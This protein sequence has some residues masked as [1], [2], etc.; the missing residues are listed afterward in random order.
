MHENGR[1]GHPSS[2]DLAWGAVI[3]AV[4]RDRRFPGARLGQ[5]TRG[6]GLRS[7]TL[8]E[9]LLKR[10]LLYRIPRGTC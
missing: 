4:L 10:S 8:G 3:R 7:H 2:L 6:L 9:D 5:G 1:G